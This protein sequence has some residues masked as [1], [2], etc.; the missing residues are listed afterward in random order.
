MGIFRQFSC[1][2]LS[3]GLIAGAVAGEAKA[4]G[5]AAVKSLDDQSC[6]I[7]LEADPQGWPQVEFQLP[8]P[9]DKINYLAITIT[10]V[11]PVEALSHGITVFAGKPSALDASYI[12][13]D[14]K[15]GA[16]KKFR[17]PLKPGMALPTTFT[18]AAKM[19]Q[20]A[21]VLKLS[22]PEFG[23]APAFEPDAPKAR[24]QPLPPVKFRGKPFFPI[25]AYDTAKL[26]QADNFASIDPEFIAAGG[27]FADLGLL[28]MP[29]SPIYANHGQPAIF[30]ALDRMQ[31]NPDYEKIAFL[32]G[33]GGALLM[34]K[35]PEDNNAGHGG[36]FLPLNAEQRKAHAAVLTEALRKLRQYPNI[37]GYTMDEPENLIWTYYKANYSDDWKKSG[38]ASI[39]GKMVEWL[40]WVK[41]IIR[42]EHPEAQLMPIIA[43]WSTYMDVSDMYDVLVVNQYPAGEKGAPEFSAPW[44]EVSY[45]AAMAVAAARAHGKTVIYMPPMF[46]LM[47][48]D[49]PYGFCTLRE[50]R[51]VN[52]APVTRGAMGIHGWRLNRCSAEYR[53]EVIYPAMKEL[54]SLSDFFLGEWLDDQVRSNHDSASVDY[55][56]KFRTRVR[57]IA[58]E[59]DGELSQETD[60]VPDVSYC[61]RKRADGKHLLLVVNNRREALPSVD[62]T[63]SVSPLPTTLVD[64]IDGHKVQVVPN[65][66]FSDQ[67]EPFDVHAYLW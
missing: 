46:N 5:K 62:F 7:R 34:E 13:T 8:Q 19:P 12:H 44:Y 21:T 55:L 37:I 56:R 4:I 20:T 52:F 14:L 17:F 39:A 9:A 18:I 31:S 50:Q 26:G 29:D 2:L 66:T 42:A 30:A 15:P 11:E 35:S 38:D 41:P 61:L 48:A 28:N 67:F 54:S 6:E 57:L 22:Q 1:L 33:L 59:E 40:N 43:W 10:Q 58:G 23:Y 25:G 51:Y 32:V 63:L 53:R 64:A 3:A 60:M 49:W 16:A 47:D 65:G 24:L 27:N 45:D 36:M